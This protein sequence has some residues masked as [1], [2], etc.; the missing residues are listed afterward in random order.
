MNVTF[1]TNFLFFL[2][3][4][5]LC[6]LIAGQYCIYK[7]ADCPK[8]FQ[9]GYV[10]WDDE[11]YKNINKKGGTLPDGVYDRDTLIK[12]CC[13]ADGDKFTPVTLPVMSSFYLMMS[14]T[15]ECQRVKGAV[16]TKEFIRFDNEDSG[17]KDRQYG[18]HPY[19]AGIRNHKL[20]YCYYESKC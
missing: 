2:S 3:S 10:Y 11:D 8:G 12:Y 15:S 13:R 19:G 1:S 16:A 17:N 4:C 14:N 18:S 5:F 6:H 20:Y 9:E 7:K